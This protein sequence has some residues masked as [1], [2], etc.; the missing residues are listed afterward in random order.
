MSS[1]DYNTFLTVLANETPAATF[2]GITILYDNITTAIANVTAGSTLDNELRRHNYKQIRKNLQASKNRHKVVID[3]ASH[4]IDAVDKFFSEAMEPLVEQFAGLYIYNG[5]ARLKLNRSEL[6]TN[7]N[8]H[9]N[10]LIPL[11]Y[12]MHVDDTEYVQ[13]HRD[14]LFTY[15]E[16]I[17]INM[18]SNILCAIQDL[19]Y[20]TFCWVPLT[21]DSIKYIICMAAAT[22]RKRPILPTSS[23]YTRGYR[24]LYDYAKSQLNIVPSHTHPADVIGYMTK[25]YPTISEHRRK[26]MIDVLGSQFGKIVDPGTTNSK[27]DIICCAFA[28]NDID[29]MEQTVCTILIA[30]YNTVLGGA[31]ETPLDILKSLLAAIKDDTQKLDAH[32]NALRQH[33]VQFA[34]RINQADVP[35]SAAP[36]DYS[37]LMAKYKALHHE[38][39]KLRS[40]NKQLR[41]EPPLLVQQVAAL[42]Q[43]DALARVL[44]ATYKRPQSRR[45]PNDSDAMTMMRAIRDIVE[46]LSRPQ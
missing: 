22:I 38:N 40:E 29:L 5:L 43:D 27:L 2:A 4:D 42:S 45:D 10:I 16:E 37:G 26:T 9:G 31:P 8:T 20:P 13:S 17:N 30:K 21:A 25:P 3:N 24:G 15:K 12:F 19:N 35:H 34:Q 41:D 1:L 44:K 36:V 11:I 14:F 33:L 39:A 32:Y 18:A 28:Q 6:R 23:C 46:S 7:A